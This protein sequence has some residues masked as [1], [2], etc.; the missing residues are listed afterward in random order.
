[1]QTAD[2]LEGKITLTGVDFRDTSAKH[3]LQGL[4]RHAELI[5][6]EQRGR[7]SFLDNARS[8][9]SWLAAGDIAYDILDRR[10]GRLPLFEMPRTMPRLKRSCRGS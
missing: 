8:R 5:Q 2:H 1:M 7:E 4:A 9:R 6:R 3:A 10:V